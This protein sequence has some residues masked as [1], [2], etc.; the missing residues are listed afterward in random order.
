MRLQENTPAKNF[1]TE[2]VFGNPISLDLYKGKKV[3]LSFLRF[4]GCPVCNLHIHKILQRKD[5]IDKNNLSI[6][7]V[8]E[9]DPMTVKKYITNENLPFTFISDPNQ[10][11][12]DLYSVE[13][14]WKK[15]IKW[16]LTFK[17]L[18]DGAKGFLK[19]NKFSSMK[20]SSNRVE[21][22][23]LIDEKGILEK[24]HYGE[25]VGDYMPVSNYL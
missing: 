22:E 2:D 23:F 18:S 15:F 10:I 3:L 4:T 19:Y 14:S 13:K 21:A 8:F 24:I 9:S 11:L 1:N 16:G 5:E 20:G 6:L 25:M 17:G 7:F 12:Y